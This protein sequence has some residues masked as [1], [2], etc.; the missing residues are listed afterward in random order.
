RN[1]L[2]YTLDKILKLMHP[3]MPFVT[4]KIWLTMPHEG[5]SI[6][7]APYPVNHDEFKD[8]KAEKDMAALIDLIKVV[9]NIRSQA[10][11]P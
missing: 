4:E 7:V 11:A 3:M 6:V 1:I 2:A 8:A 10:N 9:R 5:E